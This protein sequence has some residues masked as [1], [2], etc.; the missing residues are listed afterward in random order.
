MNEAAITQFITDT[1]EDVQT[2]VADGNTLFFH[3]ADR[4]MPFATLVT[5][6]LYDQVSDLNRPGVLRLNVG[7]G[8]E[9]YRSL[10]GNDIEH[11]DGGGHDFTMLDR[12]MPH[13]VYGRMHW[14]CVLSPGAATFKRVKALLAEAYG[15]AANRSARRAE[16]A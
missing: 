10:F 13:P 4:Q 6:D 2:A 14:L 12:I 7:V 9:T 5:N 8:K 15:L 3:G 16:R 11:A 1:F